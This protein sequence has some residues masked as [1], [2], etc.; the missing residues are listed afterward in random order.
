MEIVSRL[1]LSLLKKPTSF[2][3]DFVN[4]SA[5]TIEHGLVGRLDAENQL[6]VP[7]NGDIAWEI[8]VTY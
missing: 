2:V 3:D 1:Y 7:I 6:C 8:M 4:V 5:S